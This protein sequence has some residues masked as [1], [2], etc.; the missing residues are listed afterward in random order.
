MGPF[1]LSSF[2]TSE[3]MYEHVLPSSNN[4]LTFMHLFPLDTITETVLRLTLDLFA[5]TVPVCSDEDEL[6]PTVSCL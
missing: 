6:L 3:L 2:A 4:A 1:K 5:A